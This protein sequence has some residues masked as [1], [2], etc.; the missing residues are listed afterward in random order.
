MLLPRQILLALTLVLIGMAAWWRHS[1]EEASPELAPAPA[2]RRPDYTVDTLA[3]TVMD[4]TGAPARRLIAEELRHYADDGSSELS[5][6]FLTVY[7]EAVPPWEIR[8][9]SAWIS[10]DGERIL[11]QGEVF[12][13][14]E[15]TASLRPLHLHTSELLVEPKREYAETG[16]PVRLTSRGEWLTS[17]HGARVWLG[18]ALRVEL[19]GRARA[20][21]ATPFDGGDAPAPD[22]PAGNPP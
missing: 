6:P 17:A 18:E 11:M 4:E 12:I 14:R 8:S 1:G 19:Y 9:Q 21:L 7:N 15:A 20:Q 3:A 22:A 5:R 13:D 2:E 10:A 16:R